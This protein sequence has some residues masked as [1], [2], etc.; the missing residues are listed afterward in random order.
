MADG[1]SMADEAGYDSCEDDESLYELEEEEEEELVDLEE[2]GDKDM[3]KVAQG[4]ALMLSGPTSITS[5]NVSLPKS[6]TKAKW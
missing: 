1:A 6:M 3:F 2:G 4:D 5:G